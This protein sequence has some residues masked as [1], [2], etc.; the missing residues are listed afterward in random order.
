MFHFGVMRALHKQRMLP[1][2]ICG[3]SIGALLAALLGV[4]RDDELEQL[5]N[6][7]SAIK[8]DAFD[9]LGVLLDRRQHA[10]YP[11]PPPLFHLSLQD[12]SGSARRKIT[13]FLKHGVLMDV[14]KLAA[15]CREN[16]GDLTFQVAARGRV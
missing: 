13:R 3:T 8:F 1:H 9:R 5:W 4:R 10:I 15:F 6:D 16:L 2:I 7:P 12:S 11:P 14:K